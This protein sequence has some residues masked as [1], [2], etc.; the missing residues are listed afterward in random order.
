[1][2]STQVDA[3]THQLELPCWKSAT[4]KEYL[5]YRDNPN[6]ERVRLFYNLGYLWVD[7]GGEGINHSSINALFTLIFGFWFLQ[8]NPSQVY[9]LLGGCQIE[10]ENER[11]AAPDLMLYLGENYP[12]WQEGERRFI[13][14][15]QWRTPD[16]VGEIADTT[17]ATDMDEKKQLY[18]GLGIPEYWVIDV[19]GKRLFCFV[20]Q[21][22]GKYQES[23]VSRIFTALPIEL[24]NQTLQQ[25]SEQG[26]GRAANWFSQQIAQIQSQPQVSEQ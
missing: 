6:L 11:A 25:A 1:M 9:S 22:D 20:L 18:A 23:F 2:I 17:L 4:W 7:R 5:S 12:K 3:N 14:L 19:R 13:N 10:K 15:N 16:L 8:T 24:L 26:N 21:E